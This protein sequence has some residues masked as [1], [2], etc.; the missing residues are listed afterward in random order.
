MVS[1]GD[2]F[3]DALVVAAAVA[4]RMAGEATEEEAE[5]GHEDGGAGGIAGYCYVA[6]AVAAGQPYMVDQWGAF[7]GAF[8]SASV[9][10]VVVDLYNG[11]DEHLDS[12]YVAHHQKGYWQQ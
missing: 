2:S 11:C 8:D 9:H 12:D 1:R 10:V 7:G 5:E 4:A 3:D 6:E